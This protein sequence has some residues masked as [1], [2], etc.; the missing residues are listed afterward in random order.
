MKSVDLSDAAAKTIFSN[1]VLATEIKPRTLF[2]LQKPPNGDG[3]TRAWG[4]VKQN[5]RIINDILD[6]TGGF[7]PKTG[8]IPL[9]VHQVVR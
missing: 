6:S 1:N 9:P 7:V 2:C 5:F 4:T 3:L 8:A